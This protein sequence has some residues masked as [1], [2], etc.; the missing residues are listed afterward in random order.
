MGEDGTPITI[1]AGCHGLTK[2][3]FANV[4]LCKG[5]SHGYAERA[6]ANNVLPAGHQ[7]VTLQSD[8]EPSIIDVK[9][10]AGTQIPTEIVYEESPV[11]DSNANGSIE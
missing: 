4:V 9:H 3:F 8:Q 10:K 7:K 2:A 11:G 6:I 1:P 5:T